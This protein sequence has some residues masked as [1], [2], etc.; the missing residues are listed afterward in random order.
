M[1]REEQH[2]H[3]T[4]AQYLESRCGG[5]AWFTTFPSGGG[6]RLRGA[7][8]RGM[9]LKAGVP[10]ILFIWKGRAYWVEVKA[11]KGK[12]SVS[13]I[14]CQMDL[15]QAG[16]EVATVRSVEDVEDALCRWQIVVRAG[17]MIA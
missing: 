6:G 15:K 11:P 10:D 16:C 2:L 7:I 17:V 14:E 12:L 5:D 13:Q 9:G 8:L 4:I 3:Q 1:K